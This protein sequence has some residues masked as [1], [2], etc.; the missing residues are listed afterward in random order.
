M[1]ATAAP[2]M[3]HDR[4]V[5][6]ML[7]KTAFFAGREPESITPAIRELVADVCALTPFEKRAMSGPCQ[8]ET[9][10]MR[11]FMA[12]AF[13]KK[14]LQEEFVQGVKAFALGKEIKDLEDTEPVQFGLDRDPCKYV[15]LGSEI[16]QLASTYRVFVPES[17][18]PGTAGNDLILKCL[19]GFSDRG[20]DAW[21]MKFVVRVS[22]N[23]ILL[24]FDGRVIERMPGT[25]IGT[26]F[27]VSVC[28]MDFA[29]RDHDIDDIHHYI[30]NWQ[31]VFDLYS[32][33]VDVFK[34]AEV[35]AIAHENPRDF[36]IRWRHPA[37]QLDGAKFV[38]DV[39]RMT[40]LRFTAMCELHVQ[41][42]V[43]VAVGLGVFA[44]DALGIAEQVRELSATAYRDVLQEN[45]YPGLL[46]VILALPIFR[47]RDNY[48]FFEKAFAT[49][50]GAVP[51]LIVDQDMHKVARVCAVKNGAKRFI[52]SE[53]NPGDSHGV[54]GEYWENF[55]PGTEEKL[56]LTTLGLLTQHHAVNP[57][58]LDPTCITKLNL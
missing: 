51:V 45:T 4:G 40:H 16:K 31:N 23:P 32:D 9:I 39:K 28:G 2:V 41:V 7:F 46:L 8:I 5:A 47:A 21:L 37:V 55:G 30:T 48:F 54:F 13:Q 14:T 17:L 10:R 6:S 25:E 49:Y 12:R 42:A 43:E 29:C 56:A 38:A 3:G 19:G 53:L 15:L 35:P 11:E 1:A 20:E 33:R 50:T 34:S 18:F 58:V 27:L 22:E 57:R 24:E 52:T 36:S 26:I 44:G